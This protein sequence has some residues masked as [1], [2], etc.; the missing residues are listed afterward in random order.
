[1]TIL[2]NFGDTWAITCDLLGLVP[3]DCRWSHVSWVYFILSCVQCGI[4]N[5]I[6]A[7]FFSFVRTMTSILFPFVIF[8]FIVMHDFIS[9][10]LHVFGLG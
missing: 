10:A 3:Q 5:F 8:H 6:D 1:M 4:V 2:G 9:G 7:Y